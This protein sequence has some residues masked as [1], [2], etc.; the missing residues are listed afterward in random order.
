MAKMR[1][2]VVLEE[3]VAAEM[4]Q[5]FDGNLSKGVN[6]ALEDWLKKKKQRHSGFGLFKGEGPAL[7]RELRKIR[8]ENELD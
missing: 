1:Y 4:R 3:H 5:M 7:L 6:T 2:T 8:E